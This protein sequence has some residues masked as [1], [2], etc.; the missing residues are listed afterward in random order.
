MLEAVKLRYF[1][2]L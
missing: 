1:R 2:S